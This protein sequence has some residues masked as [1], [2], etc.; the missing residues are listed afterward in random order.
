M[1]RGLDAATVLTPYAS[2]IRAAGIAHVGRYLKSLTVGE[3]AALH[4]AGLG[5]WLIFESTADRAL[6][7]ASAG[8]AD[9]VTAARQAQ[10]LGAPPS[11]AIA[12]TVDLD[13][14]V[15][16]LPQVLAYLDV[17]RSSSSRRGLTYA[18]GAVLSRDAGTPW[19]AGAIGWSGSRAY[20]ATK[21]AAIVQ[22]PQV[23]AHA[24]ATW[25]GGTWPALP[26]AYDPDL[27]ARDDFGLWLP[28]TATTAPI[29]Q[30][31]VPSARTI[32]ATL[33][34]AG[35]SPGPVDGVWGPSSAA[36]LAAYYRATNNGETA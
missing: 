19:L 27:L 31:T 4:A 2:A 36:A 30:S 23:N 11:T 10:A 17:F 15:A 18:C 28:P 9:G 3:V 33:V 16:Q 7:G 8:S 5:L 1:I 34:T 25:E 22:G 35:Y 32:Q 29:P 24:T 14:S 21:A 26:F 13:P 6:A 12:A 20:Y